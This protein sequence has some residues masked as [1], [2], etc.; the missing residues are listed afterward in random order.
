VV[1]PARKKLRFV[2]LT[3]FLARTGARPG[4]GPVQVSLENAMERLIFAR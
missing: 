3:P 4:S 1:D 2:V